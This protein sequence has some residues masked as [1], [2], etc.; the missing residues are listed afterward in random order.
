MCLKGFLMFCVLAMC[1]SHLLS[2]HSWAH[3]TCTESCKLLTR[4]RASI[5]LNS[6]P[7]PSVCWMRSTLSPKSISGR[8]GMCISSANLH[9]NKINT[10]ANHCKRGDDLNITPTSTKHSYSCCETENTHCS[11]SLDF[12]I[13]VFAEVT[14]HG[15]N[16]KSCLLLLKPWENVDIAEG[17]VL[18]QRTQSLWVKDLHPPCCHQCNNAQVPTRN[19][20]S[21]T[22]LL[23]IWLVEAGVRE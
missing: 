4:L 9:E 6:M 15:P 18:I 17:V 11:I 16:G 2:C 21:H 1:K 22:L 8:D 14:F 10:T 23:I 3:A 20:L 13:W 12:I 19:L 7:K 5:A